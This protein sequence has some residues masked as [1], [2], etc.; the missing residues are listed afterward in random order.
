LEIRETNRA[1]ASTVVDPA[2]RA[3]T[4]EEREQVLA[5]VNRLAAADRLVIAL[6]HFEQLG[7]QEMAEVLECPPG[8]VKSRLARAMSRLRAELATTGAEVAR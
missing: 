3:V 5:A 8:T 6:R 2:E 7:E 1:A 4:A